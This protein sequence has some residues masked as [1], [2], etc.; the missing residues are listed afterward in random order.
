MKVKKERKKERKKEK[1]QRRGRKN[2][3]TIE[4][5]E[6]KANVMDERKK[7]GR[8]T[9]SLRELFSFFLITEPMK[10]MCKT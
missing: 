8:A 7:Y 3:T 5:R 4:E 1:K 6:K 2:K 10:W 9:T